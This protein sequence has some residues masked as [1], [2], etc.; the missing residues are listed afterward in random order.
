M[1]QG[2]VEYS[3][4]RRQ[5]RKVNREVR[6]DRNAPKRKL[7]KVL[8]VMCAI[9]FIA[10]E[11]FGITMAKRIHDRD[12]AKDLANE[13]TI[14]LS[15]VNAGLISGDQKMLKD[16]HQ[17]YRT[18]L[19]QFN[20]NSYVAEEHADLLEQLNNY[21]AI[22]SAEEK[23][24]HLVK[25][26]TA[27]MMLQKELQDVDLTK[28]SAKSMIDIKERLEDFR[29]SLEELN[30]ER[31][32]SAIAELTNYSNDLIKLIDKTSVCVGTCTEKTIKSRQ[33]DLTKIF[34]KYRDALIEC[35]AEI[36]K[37]YSPA[38]LVESLKML[39]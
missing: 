15:S 11:I 16:A 23:D 28:V 36:S 14:E 39:Q 24:A 3:R 22:L 1:K 17:Q 2:I 32:A 29:N 13:A 12:L 20:A 8:L 25:L 10:A 31:F 26:R 6:V 19:D 5:I 30:D 21:D 9:V 37:Y 18:T 27:I 35:D 38:E 4:T 33:E 34:D 7:I